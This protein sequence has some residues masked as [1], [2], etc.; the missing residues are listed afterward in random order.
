MAQNADYDKA[1]EF[2][3]KGMSDSAFF[4]FNQAKEL[5]SQ[6]GDSFGVGKCLL[7]MAIISTEKG[8]YFGAQELSLSAQQYFRTDSLAQHVFIRSNFNNLGIATYL[9]EDYPH[10]LEFYDQALRYAENDQDI[11]ICLNNKAKVYDELGEYS[12]ALD[13]YQQ[14]LKGDSTVGREYARTLSN[15]A[16]TRWKSEPKYNP[17]NELMKALNI[18]LKEKDLWGLNASYSHLSKYFTQTEPQKAYDYTKKMLDVA[19]RLSSGDDQLQALGRLISLAP[20]NQ[21]KKYFV[22]YQRLQ[23]SLQST[24]SRARNQ[25]ALIRYQSERMR[26]EKIELQRENDNKNYQ[27]IILAA[28]IMGVIISAYFYIR[29]RRRRINLEAERRIQEGELK[30]SKRVHDVVANGLYRI[31]SEMENSNSIDQENL[32][33]RIDD[34][35][36][37]SRDISYV[38]TGNDRP[39]FIQVVTNLFGAFSSPELKLAV[40]GNES[41]TW[42]GISETVED[43][44]EVIF[45]EIMV[46]MDKHSGA[47]KVVLRFDRKQ[48]GLEISY[49]DNGK[50]IPEG[51]PQKNGLRNTGNRIESMKGTITFDPGP[52]NKGLN[53]LIRIPLY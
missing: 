33:S 53:I 28:G 30:T 46:N 49:R 5:F 43:E 31:M 45:Q 21:E 8:D 15:I 27:L 18:R 25:F 23:D 13:L 42:Q 26:A 29:R 16:M 32:I 51:T 2:R 47:D 12:K 10:A 48:E 50:G 38:S 19:T 20:P 1:F 39:A 22:T 11:H 34:L 35:Y 14:V 52:E 41:E 37:K 40:I 36:E 17:V 3:I 4:Y 24:R 9:L 44:L 7:N 6:H